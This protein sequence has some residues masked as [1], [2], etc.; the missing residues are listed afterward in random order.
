M[1]SA[2]DVRASHP[3]T[4]LYLG[5]AFLGEYLA[6][7]GSLPFVDYVNA[8]FAEGTIPHRAARDLARY[9]AETA[10]LLARPAVSPPR[11]PLPGP[12]VPL[13]LSPDV[14]LLMYGADLPG[15]LDA[16]R[17]GKPAQPH[18]RRAWL[19]LVARGAEVEARHL[20]RDEGWTLEWFREPTSLQSMGDDGDDEGQADEVALLWRQGVL[21]RA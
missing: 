16:L 13:R 5:E 3:L 15:M 2:A 11:E 19:L 14:A 4:L 1:P 8:R 20:D 7:G 21:V 6:K 18:P 10:R 12:E 17:D 9:E